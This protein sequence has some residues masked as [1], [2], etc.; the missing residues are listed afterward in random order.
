MAQAAQ[1]RP[2]VLAETFLATLFDL[3]MAANSLREWVRRAEVA[4]YFLE[5]LPARVVES[6][7][8]SFELRWL[9]GVTSPQEIL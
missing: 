5:A 1:L 4:S 9:G 3:G 2:L 8:F 7:G 6:H